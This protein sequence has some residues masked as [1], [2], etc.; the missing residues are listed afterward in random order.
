MRQ[1]GPWGS[2]SEDSCFANACVHIHTERHGTSTN[3]A[4]CGTSQEWGLISNL[5]SISMRVYGGQCVR[6]RLHDWCK[7]PVMGTGLMG[8]WQVAYRSRWW[9][10][11]EVQCFFLRYLAQGQSYL[12]VQLPIKH[13]ICFMA[14]SK[15]APW[16]RHSKKHIHNRGVSPT[17]PCPFLLKKSHQ[18]RAEHGSTIGTLL[19][20]YLAFCQ[21][22][23][24]MN[25]SY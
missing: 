1:L 7:V 11:S 9:W 6:G 22:Q 19:G 21:P 17:N 16:N 25:H 20:H 8:A 10:K 4:L 18:F 14:N 24:L 13:F 23:P 12:G 2:Y 3:A 5:K 15:I